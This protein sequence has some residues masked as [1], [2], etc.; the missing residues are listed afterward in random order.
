[1]KMLKKYIKIVY[2]Q[3]NFEGPG[4]KNKGNN[5]PGGILLSF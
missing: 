2:I 3:K 4:M 1:M 5:Q